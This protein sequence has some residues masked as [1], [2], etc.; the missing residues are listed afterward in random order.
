[1][2]SFNLLFFKAFEGSYW[3]SGLKADSFAFRMLPRDDLDVSFGKSGSFGKKVDERFIR[4]S[5]YGWCCE[6]YPV[7]AVCFS[8]NL[9][10][11]RT[12]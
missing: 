2:T 11:R 5:L 10:S 6:F 12:G 1:M 8:H 3:G 4:F 9:G 7:N